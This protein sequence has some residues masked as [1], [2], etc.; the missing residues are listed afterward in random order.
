MDGTP[1][2]AGIQRSRYGVVSSERPRNGYGISL[3]EVLLVAPYGTA[4]ALPSTTGKSG[5]ISAFTREQVELEVRSA[6]ASTRPRKWE[7][8]AARGDDV[9][10]AAQRDRRELHSAPRV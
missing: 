9:L 2:P 8:Q 4:D 6:A 10:E 1:G 5:M 7:C 3:H